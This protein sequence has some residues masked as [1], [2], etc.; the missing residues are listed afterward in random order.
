[1]ANR[2]RKNRMG[3]AD[4]PL[5]VT[6]T[7]LVLFGLIAIWAT[8][9]PDAISETGG[10][11]PIYFVVA[12]LKWLVIGTVAAAAA[13][14]VGYRFLAR[15]SIFLMLAVL[16]LLV[17][18]LIV[19]H[20]DPIAARWLYLPGFSIQPSEIAKPIM[21]IY[22]ARWLSS[23]GDKLNDNDSGL[24][25]FVFLVGVYVALIMFEPNLSTA[26]ILATVALIMFLLAGANVKR[27]SMMI[28]GA[29]GIAVVAALAVKYQRERIFGWL[30]GGDSGAAQQHEMVL[31][32][33]QSAGMVGH[34][35]DELQVQTQQT[36]GAH[37][38]FIFAFTTYGFG[39]VAALLLVAA[40]L[41]LGYRAVRIARQAPDN[42][43]AL[44]G[45]GI[46]C[47]LLLQALIHIGVN[48]G[49]LPITGMTLPF[50][51]YGGSSLLACMIGVGILLSI[52][53]D[54]GRRETRK[55]AA[56]SYGGRYRRP[57]VS[58]SHRSA[59]AARTRARR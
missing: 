44:I 16:G 35:L 4:Y 18:V 42:L 54:G 12:Q 50:I 15:M 25:P 30:F 24:I 10:S 32:L 5:L 38:D 55:G 37:M 56:Y 26:I 49:A 28:A 43:G 52:S 33:T 20:D 17:A 47:W 9:I 23:K 21:I 59:G 41:Y 39:I 57:R 27:V 8:S 34:G 13:Y 11:L 51:S 40:F 48:V 53:R 7:V 36:P 14:V 46:G 45:A 2:V 22:L 1:M 6:A 58:G 29:F 3:E 19:N 31:N